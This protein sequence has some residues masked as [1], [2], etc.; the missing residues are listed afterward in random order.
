MAV[1]VPELP[2][3]SSLVSA[4]AVLPLRESLQRDRGDHGDKGCAGLLFNRTWFEAGNNGLT[5][6]PEITNHL[7]A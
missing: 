6:A 2:L 1:A 5:A 3:H 4:R 7:A